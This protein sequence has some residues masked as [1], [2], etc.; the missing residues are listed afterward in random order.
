MATSPERSEE[1]QGASA[2]E[3]ATGGG[4]IHIEFPGRVLIGAERGADAELLR[5]IRESLRK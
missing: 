1:A 2:P 3:P 4:A 5:C